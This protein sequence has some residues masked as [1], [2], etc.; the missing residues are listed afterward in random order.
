ML[1]WLWGGQ[2]ISQFGGAAHAIAAVFASIPV[3]VIYVAS[4]LFSLCSCTGES[5]GYPLTEHEHEMPND[6]SSCLLLHLCSP[7]M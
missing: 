5:F 7:R 6:Q 1:Y 2:L 4:V 3:A